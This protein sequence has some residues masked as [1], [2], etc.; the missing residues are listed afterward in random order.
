MLE[1][2]FQNK[3]LYFIS[4]GFVLLSPGIYS[5]TNGKI[6]VRYS[7]SAIMQNGDVIEKYI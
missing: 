3:K 5:N 4:A 6:S 1:M 7:I 2:K